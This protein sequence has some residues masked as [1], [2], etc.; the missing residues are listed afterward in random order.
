[1]LFIIGLPVV[2][3]ILFCLSIGKDPIGLQLAIVN[4][5]LSSSTESCVPSTG[6]D[7]HM[8]SCR[9]LKHLEKRKVEY[10]PYD[11]ENEAR[12]AVTKGWA[13]GVITFPKNYSDSLALRIDEGKDVDEFAIDYADMSVVMDMSSE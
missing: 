1:M 11:T 2:Q 3:I 12:H 8:L 10:L 9:F 7:M 13:W 6:C 4:N 5:E